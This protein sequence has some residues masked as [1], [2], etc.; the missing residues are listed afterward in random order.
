MAHSMSTPNKQLPQFADDDKPSWLGD[1]NEAMVKIDAEFGRLQGVINDQ[2][3]Q[4]NN[5]ADK[6]V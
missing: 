5:K 1:F 6:V 2:Q 3:T 4:I